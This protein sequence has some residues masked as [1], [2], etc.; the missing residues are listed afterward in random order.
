MWP[1]KWKGLTIR[2]NTVI[3]Y[4]KKQNLDTPKSIKLNVTCNDGETFYYCSSP[5]ELKC[6]NLRKHCQDVRMPAKCQCNQG[7]ARD[8][9]NNCI[10]KGNCTK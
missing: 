1:F 7:Y 10:P 4:L 5:C 2:I 3:Y 6:S 9:N 8:N